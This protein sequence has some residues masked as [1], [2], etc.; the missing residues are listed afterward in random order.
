MPS[1][2]WLTAR[3]EIAAILTGVAV[4]APIAETIRRVFEVPPKLA[5][6]F[7]CVAIMGVSK[8]EPQRAMALR[9]REYTARLRLIIQDADLNRAADLIDAFQEAIT[10]AFDQNVTLNGKVSLLHGPQ[11]QEAETLDIGGQSQWGADAFVRFVM[12]DD[13]VFAP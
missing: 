8:G 6:D 11:W 13:I 2:N 7:P 10:D 1:I 12:V 9:E 3:A 4:T 5:S